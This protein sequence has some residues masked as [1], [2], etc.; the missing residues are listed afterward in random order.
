MHVGLEIQKGP[1]C[2]RRCHVGVAQRGM[3]FYTVGEKTCHPGSPGKRSLCRERDLLRRSP[4]KIKDLLR[5]LPCLLSLGST[6]ITEAAPRSA[7]LAA[8]ETNSDVD[9]WRLP[10]RITVAQRARICVLITAPPSVTSSR[11]EQD[12]SPKWSVVVGVH[13]SIHGDDF[14]KQLLQIRAC[15]CHFPEFIQTWTN[16]NPSEKL[17]QYRQL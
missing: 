5:C 12:V 8:P 1:F 10:A 16:K 17:Y 14:L 15:V 4:T 9:V 13:E 7:S 11:T 6:I 3:P 2:L